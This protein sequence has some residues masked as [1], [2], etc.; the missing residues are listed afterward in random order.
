MADDLF[1]E[2]DD[3]QVPDVREV[4]RQLKAHA[5]AA[6]KAAARARGGVGALKGLMRIAE[7]SHPGDPRQQLTVVLSQR[8]LIPACIGRERT[9]GI[10]R[11]ED[12]RVYNHQFLGLLPKL[13]CP[14]KSLSDLGRPHFLALARY[15]EREG[16]S[17]ATLAQY[18]CNLRS[19]LRL[20]G[21]PDAVPKGA[22]LI[23]LLTDNGIVA[24]TV[25]RT[26]IPKLSKAW[27]VRGVDTEAV[28]AAIRGEGED[29]IACQ[30][31]LEWRW[32]LRDMET[33]KLKPALADAGDRL[34]LSDGTKGGKPR[35]VLQFKDPGLARAQ[36]EA[37][38]RAQAAAAAHPGGRLCIA[39]LT[40]EQMKNRFHEVVRRHLITK[41]GAGVTPHGLRHQ[42]GIDL[43]FDLTGMPAPVLGLLP[44]A[45]YRRRASVVRDGMK[46]V[47]QALGHERPSISAAYVGSV[48][49]LSREQTKR[50]AA[51]LEDLD[52]AG[53]ALAAAGVT[54]AWLVGTG[55]RGAMVLPGEALELVVRL[56][57]ECLALS[58]ADLGR[59]LEKLRE[60]AEAAMGRPVR[61]NP[62][63]Q[64]G[65]PPDGAE[66]S[67]AFGVQVRHPSQRSGAHGQ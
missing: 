63:F 7:K 34:V 24:G 16:I 35:V 15:W 55:G 32:G 4:N 53:P 44:A 38:D 40:P 60:E 46:L 6:K 10:K 67:F 5:Q 66:I 8:E 41:K 62:W 58:A 52:A 1:G 29:V 54:D 2:D 28:I 9:I 50:I 23:Q 64:S 30:L 45:E 56:S 59:R 13:R 3:E 18:Y 22:A 42:Y 47:A 49:S 57:A 26:Y 51:Y 20:L 12:L 19:L 11:L 61:V 36:R 39:G 43:F 48:G 14:V 31:E 25:G 17:E 65:P 21:K 33:F 37:L 27:S